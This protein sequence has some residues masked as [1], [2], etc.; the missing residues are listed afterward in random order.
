V[1]LV[2][3]CLICIYPC[4]QDL[5]QAVLEGSFKDTGVLVDGGVRGGGNVLSR[6]MDAANV[7]Q[8]ADDLGDRLRQGMGDLGPDIGDLGADLAADV[9]GDELQRPCG[10][11]AGGDVGALHG[12][13]V[14]AVRERA[15]AR[16][17]KIRSRWG[18][19]SSGMRHAACPQLVQWLV[20]AQ[21]LEDGIDGG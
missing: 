5:L 7:L 19:A 10:E 11:I 4:I 17:M 3:R 8:Q 9:A 15:P 21:D 12:G 2:Q 18:S 6:A 16:T 1:E 20:V 13:L 14:P